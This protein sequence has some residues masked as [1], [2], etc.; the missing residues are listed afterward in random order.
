MV[1]RTVGRIAICT[2]KL[3]VA[4]GNTANVYVEKVDTIPRRGADV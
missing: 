4:Y 1:G 3:G 2:A